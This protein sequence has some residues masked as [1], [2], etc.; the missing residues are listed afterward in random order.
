MSKQ[1]QNYT[2][3]KEET[4]Y[5]YKIQPNYNAEHGRLKKYYQ[6]SIKQCY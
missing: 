1:K 2:K 6:T 3:S 5:T 4:I